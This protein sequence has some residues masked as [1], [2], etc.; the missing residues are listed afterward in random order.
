MIARLLLTRIGDR[1]RELERRAEVLQQLEAAGEGSSVPVEL[2][3]I[4]EECEF[5]VGLAREIR[6]A[7]RRGL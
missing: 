6:D 4:V 5:L 3:R 1:T 7:V 2:S